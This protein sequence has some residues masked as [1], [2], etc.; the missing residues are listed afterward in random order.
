MFA[1]GYR[2]AQTCAFHDFGVAAHIDRAFGHVDDRTLYRGSLFDEELRGIADQTACIAQ[3]LRLASGSQAGE[4]AAQGFVVEHE[5]VP[6]VV[7]GKRIAFIGLGFLR[8]AVAAAGYDGGALSQGFAGFERENGFHKFLIRVEIA[9]NEEVVAVGGLY[10]GI[11][12][13]QIVLGAVGIGAGDGFLPFFRQSGD[14]VAQQC[15][16]AGKGEGKQPRTCFDRVEEYYIFH[17]RI[18]FLF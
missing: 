2:A 1:K 17:I 7:E 12:C 15:H 16:R 13:R 5:D 14:A 8:F 18:V 11:F 10:H 6:D 4:V 9:G 3:G